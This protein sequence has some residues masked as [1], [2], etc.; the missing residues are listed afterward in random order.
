MSRS[1]VQSFSAAA[2]PPPPLE[3]LAAILSLCSLCQCVGYSIATLALAGF[4][5]KLLIHNETTIEFQ[6]KMSAWPCLRSK[7]GAAREGSSGCAG[8]L[9][10][11]KF[12]TEIL[13]AAV[14]TGSHPPASVHV[15]DAAL[16]RQ[17]FAAVFGTDP[18]YWPLP[19]L[20]VQPDPLENVAEDP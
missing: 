3:L 13:L 19:R 6:S 7:C 18:R 4:Q 15:N 20:P 16:Y 10:A 8:L 9:R 2:E 1:I 14:A 5:T 11:A 17:N 12:L